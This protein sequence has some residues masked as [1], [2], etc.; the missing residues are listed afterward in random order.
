MA[1]N[2]NAL[3]E[4]NEAK[5]WL[6]IS[7]TD[8]DYD[9][10]IEQ[11]I[12]SASEKIE[13]YLNRKLA[14]KS[15]TERVDGNRNVRVIL[16]HYPVESVSSVKLS[17]SWDFTVDAIDVDDY[18]ISDDG[19]LTFKNST[20][21]RGNLN[22]QVVYNGGYVLP[23]SPVQVGEALPSAIKMACIEFVKWLWN[24]DHDERF[25]V[26][27]R[28]KQGQTVSYVKGIP[29]EIMAMIEDYKRVEVT[30]AAGSADS[31]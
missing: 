2:E 22:L 20:A 28:N 30:G 25:G 31:Y 13:T 4:L 11:F 15:Y 7:L 1:L 16:K 9:F 6:G 5:N 24:I 18:H 23:N 17:S 26:S 10:K 12:N 8:T 21:K 19:V 3:L 27:S 14:A 29:Q